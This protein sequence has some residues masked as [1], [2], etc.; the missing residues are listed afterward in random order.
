MLKKDKLNS[1]SFEYPFKLPIKTWKQYI[2]WKSQVQNSLI[3]CPD[4]MNQ[5]ALEQTGEDLSQDW[6]FFEMLLFKCMLAF[7]LNLCVAHAQ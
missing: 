3:N 5:I 6:M 2:F 7:E 1:T 4:C